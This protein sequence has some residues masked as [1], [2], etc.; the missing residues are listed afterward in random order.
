MKNLQKYKSQEQA[1]N[2]H[3]QNYR[4]YGDSKGKFQNNAPDFLRVEKLLANI[5]EGNK[6]LDIGCNDGGLGRLLQKRGCTVFGVDVVEELVEMAKCKGVLAR[7]G[8][9]EKLEFNNNTFDVVVMAEV[10]EHLF[11]PLEALNEVARVLKPSGIFVGSVPHPDGALGYNKKADYHNWV[12]DADYLID[13]FADYFKNIVI[14]PTPYSERF[15]ELNNIKKD[16]PN[17]LNWVCKE[18]I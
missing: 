9:A 10:M 6:V 5:K 17:W 18:K 3:K 14:D 7:V 1:V 13:M 2:D 16:M 8:Q 12:F 15:C 11:D 4:S